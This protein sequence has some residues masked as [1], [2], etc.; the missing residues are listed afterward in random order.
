MKN[1]KDEEPFVLN[2]QM[3]VKELRWN[4]TGTYIAIAGTKQD[5]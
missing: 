1:D 5:K 4:P 3:Q 2:A